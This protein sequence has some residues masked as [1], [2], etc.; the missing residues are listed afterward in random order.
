[1]A[2]GRVIAALILLF[3]MLALAI[4]GFALLRGKGVSL[5]A[6]YN[7]LT[8]EE[9][10]KIDEVALAKFMGRVMFSLSLSMFLWVI[11]V[12]YDNIWLLVLG[13][14]VFVVIV[15]FA[16]IYTNTEDRFKRK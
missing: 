12:F 11:G 9:K 13:I 8:D 15:F 5:I 2:E 1:M 10:R 3:C 4:V 16:V 14:V 6:G 7:S